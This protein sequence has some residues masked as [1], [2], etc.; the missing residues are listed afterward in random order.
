MSAWRR[1][2]MWTVEQRQTYDRRGLRYP[3]DLTDA[4]WALVEP[5]IPP[6]RRGGRQR[7]V[8]V[9]E[10]LNGILY[11]LATGCQWRALPEDLPPKSPVHGYLTLWA[12]DG[13]LRRLHHALF[14]QVREQ[15]GK[16]A[17][18]TAAIIDSQSV[19]GAEKGGAHRSVGLRRGQE[20]QGQEAAHPGRHARPAAERRGPSRRRPGPG[21]GH[22]AAAR[23][24]PAVPVR[25]GDL[26]RRRLPGRGDRGGGGRDR[27]LAAGD[28]QPRR[29]RGLRAPGQA[30]DRG[31]D[32]RV[33]RALPEARQGLRELGRQRAR[34]PLPPHGPPSSAGARKSFSHLANLPDG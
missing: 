9:R 15:A 18:P 19:K 6:A 11:V 7:T 21:R 25:R 20:G 28:R 12:W 3:S 33:A 13:T 34:L 24:T 29:R 30:L 14:V 8:D 27:P 4:E 26:R 5:F 17:S 22:P 31:E 10:V 23:R 2:P 16:E 32:V 1:C